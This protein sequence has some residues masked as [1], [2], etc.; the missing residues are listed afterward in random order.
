MRSI[1]VRFEQ[2][3]GIRN[4]IFDCVSDEK[5]PAIRIF[6]SADL[7]L[8]RKYGI[9]LQGLPLVCRQ[10]LESMSLTSTD[11]Q[12]SV[13]E[14][15]MLNISRAAASVTSVRSK[16]SRPAMVVP[17]HAWRQAAGQA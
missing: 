3:S 13:T 1:F 11:T 16:R 2:V 6:V 9:S 8:A 10:L 5:Q 17:S 14:E 4:F 7:A 12:V 15:W